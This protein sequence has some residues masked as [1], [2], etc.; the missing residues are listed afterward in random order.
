MPLNAT[1]R[2]RPRSFV[3]WR[4]WTTCFSVATAPRN[5][6]VNSTVRAKAKQ[7]SSAVKTGLLR[8]GCATWFIERLAALRDQQHFADILAVLNEVMRLRGLVEAEGRGDL[9]LDHAV[10]P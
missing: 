1:A 10:A 6:G 4:G 3:C 7:S 2:L 8:R 9:R 5:D